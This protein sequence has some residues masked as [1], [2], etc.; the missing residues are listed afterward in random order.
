MKL[1]KNLESNPLFPGSISQRKKIYEESLWR[2]GPG[3][4][5]CIIQKHSDCSYFEECALIK[6]VLDNVSKRLGEK[7]PTTFEEDDIEFYRLTIQFLGGNEDTFLE[8]LYEN[9]LVVINKIK[10][11]K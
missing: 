10:S 3:V 2:Y 4:L 8:D 9:A 11:I 1:K 5:A 7:L 6:S